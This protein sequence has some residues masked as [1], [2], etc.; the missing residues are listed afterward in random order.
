MCI[1]DRFDLASGGDDRNI[2]MRINATDDNSSYTYIG[3]QSESIHNETAST[4]H[5]HMHHSVVLDIESTT[6]DK[7]KF[8]I[9]SINGS[10][11][12]QGQTGYSR[13]YMKFIKLADT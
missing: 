10:A 2:T 5:A 13:T 12:A 6:N 9:S 3:Y 7:V 4:S 11:A 1:R 8:A